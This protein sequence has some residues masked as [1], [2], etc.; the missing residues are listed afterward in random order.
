MRRVIIE[1]PYAG[2]VKANVAYARRC[3]RDSLAR[4]EAPIASHLLY[5][6]PSVLRDHVPEERMVAHRR[7]G[8]LAWS[9][10]AVPI[11][12]VFK[13]FHP[14]TAR[15]HPNEK[16]LWLAQGFIE[17]HTEPGAMVLDPFVGGGTT[18]VVCARLDRR[19]IGI[20]ID[21]EHFE[22][23]CR[24][25]EEAYRQPDIFIEA[26][27]REAEQVPLFAEDAA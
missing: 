17:R 25:I 14:G 18:G 2:D 4:G 23:A 13:G 22:T 15:S 21:P 20:E 26:E 19:F 7:G 10:R 16:P 27:R 9:E 24:R 3:V 12:N 5:T 8:K 6:Q 1:S 11:G